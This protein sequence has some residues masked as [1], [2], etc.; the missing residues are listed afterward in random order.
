MTCEPTRPPDDIDIPA[1][2]EKYRCER[3]KRLRSEG[4]D[5]YLR[6]TGD[7]VD[8]YERQLSIAQGNDGGASTLSMR[9]SRINTLIGWENL[10]DSGYGP[11]GF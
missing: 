6:T 3:A 5:Q 4:Q 9:P 7:F 10:P 8:Q 1:L 11:A 2:R